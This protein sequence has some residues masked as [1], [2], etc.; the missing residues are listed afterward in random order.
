MSA[1]N[2][3]LEKI[4]HVINSFAAELTAQKVILQNL[5]AHML[6]VQPLLAEETLENMKKDIIAALK[7][8]PSLSSPDED[9]RV[10]ALSVIH[11]EKFFREVAAAVS[12]MRNKL[13]QSGRH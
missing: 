5:I 3:L 8:P 1:D 13:G 9:L 7:Q 2:E 6:V 12:V 4:E 11:G 10:V